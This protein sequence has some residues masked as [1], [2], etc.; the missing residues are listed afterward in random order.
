MTETTTNLKAA[1]A[2]GY[3]RLN[4]ALRARVADITCVLAGVVAL[5]AIFIAPRLDGVWL[6]IPALAALLLLVPAAWYV[7]R[8]M[9]PKVSPIVVGGVMM[10]LAGVA[11]LAMTTFKASAAAG[12][13]GLLAFVAGLALRGAVDKGLI[14][15]RDVRAGQRGPI[16]VLFDQVESL[17]AALV[18]VLLVW[19]FGLE[20]FRIPSGSMAPTLL[21]DP[22][23][24]DRVLVDKFV[25]AWRDPVRWEPT[26]FRYPLRRT[27]PYVKRLIALPGD[28]VLIAGG[29]VY[30]R[31][32]GTGKIALARKTPEA[33]D[34]LW[35][36]IVQDMRTN[37]AWTKHFQRAGEVEFKDG[38]IHLRK[39]GS[40]VFPRGVTEDRPG[41]V[42]DHDASFGATE[43]GKDRYDRHVVGDMRLRAT[44][45]LD[46]GGEC[47]ISIIR[48]E[49]VFAL[50][51]KP[52]AGGSSLTRDNGEGAPTK[53]AAQEI[54]PLELQAGREHELE[55][56]LADGELLLVI[57]GHELAR[58][59]VGTRLLDQ[60]R[61]RDAEGAIDLAGPAALEIASAEPANGRVA[62]LELHGGAEKGARLRVHGIDRDIYYVGRMLEREGR[63]VELPF[64]VALADEQYL[65]LG[66]NSPGSLDCRF[67]TR[68]TLFMSD[69]TQVVG[70]M[71]EAAQ[72]ELVRLMIES[73]EPGEFN[74]W[75]RLF[76]VAH[77]APHERDDE[78]GRDGNI[79]IGALEMLK[80]AASNKGRAA[81]DFQ[82]EGGGYVRIAL[83]DIDRI[84]VERMPYV[85]RKL[86]VGRPFAVFLSPRGM[87]LID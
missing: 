5:V 78:P 15:G 76:R 8:R 4:P 80:A 13:A 2:K 21:G 29:D 20:A 34:A 83:A 1:P 23:T 52:G 65:V 30:I 57:N 46:D 42:T 31:D 14:R 77:F 55:F 40:A 36:P 71:D 50:E 43:T 22:V 11:L 17:A 33:R 53:L 66:D 48:D 75:Q 72:P 51:L 9:A 74:A 3:A 85:E 39:R 81:V 6:R 86:F 25:Y 63:Q 28:E 59:D 56:S 18:L 41:N 69:G 79:V 16:S 82:T 10:G 87:K 24:G 47:R 27:D 26:V 62:R 35:L 60:L 19:H 32:G 67:W 73:G 49:D 44:L 68:I 38:E 64:Q 70:S 45:I 7:H 84:Q 54:G 37:A 12:L 61:A 58:L